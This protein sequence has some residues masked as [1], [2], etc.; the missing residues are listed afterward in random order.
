MSTPT[1]TSGQTFRRVLPNKN[2]MTPNVIEYITVRD[3]EVELSSGNG[4]GGTPI[5]GVTVVNRVTLE[6]CLDLDN[7]FDNIKT[8]KLYINEL[9][10]DT[11]RL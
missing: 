9:G 1:K 10:L 2:F 11:S 8:A 4:I 5:F 3:Y 6:R 7:S